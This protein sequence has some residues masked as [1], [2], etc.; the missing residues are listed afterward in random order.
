MASFDNYHL[1]DTIYAE[2]NNNL[3]IVNA[4]VERRNLRGKPEFFILGGAAMIF[5]G[6]HYNSTLDIDTANR[7]EEAIREEV[8]PFI[9]DAASEVSI[10]PHQYQTRAKRIREDLTAIELYILAEEDLLINKLLAGRRKDIAAIRK[11]N[12]LSRI[13]KAKLF[14]I[15][16]EEL[17]A[18]DRERLY[19]NANAGGIFM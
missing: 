6:L 17:T 16:K 18:V 15:I 10:L 7:I 12:I 19:V 11:S 5:H 14:T 4:L 2:L 1:D 8:S 9:D 3:T 13:N